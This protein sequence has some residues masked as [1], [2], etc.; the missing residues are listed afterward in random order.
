MTS[1]CQVAIVGAGPYGLA[2]A[3]HLRSAKV[4]V[5][6][7]GEPMSFWANQMPAGM[8]LRS[9]WEASHISAPHGALKLERYQD[10]LGRK[11]SRPIPLDDFVNY[12][13]WFSQQVAP[14]LDRRHV[15]RIEPVADRFRL[16]LADGE[17]VQAQR[18]VVATGVAS[19]ASHPAQFDGLPAQLASHAYD[20]QALSQFSG[21]QVM[22]IGAGQS[23]MESAA[24]LKEN[25]AEVEVV[26]RAQEIIW[27]MRRLKK[28]LGPFHRLAYAPSDVGPA[29]LSWLVHMPDL[30][31]KL[32][33]DRQRRWAYRAIRPAAS[34]WLYP[35]LQDVKMT[36]GCS[37]VSATPMG[38]RL[39]VKLGNGTERVVDHALLGTG[40]KVDVDRY[41]FFAPEV[42]RAI[43]R[44]NGYPKLRA[45]FE[46]SVPG[47]HFVGAPAAISF[48]PL[49]RF[50]AGTPYTARSV[51]R[52][53]ARQAPAPVS[54]QSVYESV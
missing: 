9:S 36:T 2:V 24:L 6:V 18:V 23:A 11:I 50:V 46:S 29:G 10:E 52:F 43:E 14:D 28:A 47:L 32:S 1:T 4:D 30:F 21:K 33:E 37:V 38:G 17:I 48:G 53:V 40:Y 15:T 54:A 22:V 51:A 34:G 49:M 5:C 41:T 3:A 8:M 19:F 12:G 20:H 25:G 45:G 7:F 16:V 26:M 42:L 39:Y 31:T 44:V 35:R 27:L 13:Q